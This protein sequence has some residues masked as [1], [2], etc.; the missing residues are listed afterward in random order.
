MKIVRS[1]LTLVLNVILFVIDL[2]IISWLMDEEE[3][4]DVNNCMREYRA[5]FIRN[6]HIGK[7]TD[8]LVKEFGDPIDVELQGDEE[9]IGGIW[10]PSWY[11]DA[12]RN[13]FI[14]PIGKGKIARMSMFAQG[15]AYNIYV[16]QVEDSN[17]V[18]K[19]VYDIACPLF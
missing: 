10:W 3:R 14:M 15:G 12:G 19:V 17:G 2:R 9:R 8:D 4:V 18:W 6:A 7:T 16:W 5:Q 11:A 1:P 13:K